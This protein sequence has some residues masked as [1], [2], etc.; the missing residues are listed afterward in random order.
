MKSNEELKAEMEQVEAQMVESENSFYNKLKIAKIDIVGNEWEEIG[1]KNLEEF[2][3]EEFNSL[4]ELDEDVLFKVEVI[5]TDENDEYIK[6][7]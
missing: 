3:S 2:N 5:N 1:S 7:K 6:L 4:E